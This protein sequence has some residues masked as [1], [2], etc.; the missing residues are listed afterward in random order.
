MSVCTHVRVTD[1]QTERNRQREE[2]R[3]GERESGT[4]IQTGKASNGT[5]TDLRFQISGLRLSRASAGRSPNIPSLS[6][7]ILEAWII[8][9]LLPTRLRPIPPTPW[10]VAGIRRRLESPL[11]SG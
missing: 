6:F 3:G 8:T 11:E 9:L 1:R 4:D 10:A 5:Q 2:G 7:F